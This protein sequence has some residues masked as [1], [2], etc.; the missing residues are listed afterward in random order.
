M[1]VK[2]RNILQYIQKAYRYCSIQVTAYQVNSI[3]RI[4]DQCLDCNYLQ[5]KFVMEVNQ[6][7]VYS[8]WGCPSQ[9]LPESLSGLL[10]LLSEC[11][12]LLKATGM[13][14]F[15]PGVMDGPLF[16]TPP[17]L[18]PNPSFSAQAFDAFTASFYSP[19][20]KV[21][22]SSSGLVQIWGLCYFSSGA[23]HTSPF[24]PSQPWHTGRAGGD[25]PSMNYGNQASSMSLKFN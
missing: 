21:S 6:G 15:S 20:I 8:G 3:L 4:I 1:T 11:I 13:C 14:L 25:T 17:P 2:T 22:D 9:P 24:T 5:L 10:C 18:P 12:L 23:C 19:P 7:E 16:C